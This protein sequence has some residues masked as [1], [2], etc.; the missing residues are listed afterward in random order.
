MA[1]KPLVPVPL[2][3]QDGGKPELP[4]AN[5]GLSSSAPFERTPRTPLVGV[6]LPD[7]VIA[8]PAHDRG[9]H[10]GGADSDREERAM[11]ARRKRRRRPRRP[12]DPNLPPPMPA[13]RQSDIEDIG[14]PEE[15]KRLRHGP[16]AGDYIAE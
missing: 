5:P 13:P 16:A 10:L 14:Y 3:P 9:A 12:R 2:P 8:D 11:K 6:D 4:Q 15:G 1:D 7:D